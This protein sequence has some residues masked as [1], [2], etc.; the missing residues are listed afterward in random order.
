[1]LRLSA[2]ADNHPQL[3]EL[4]CNPV[5]VS[6]NGAVVV[7]ARI[8]IAPAPTIRP[9]GARRSTVGPFEPARGDDSQIISTS[10]AG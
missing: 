2:L 6:E 10:V 1:M 7:D 5:I 9:L 4:D 8:R 3:A